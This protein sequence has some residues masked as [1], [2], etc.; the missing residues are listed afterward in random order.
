MNCYCA[1]LG[2][3]REQLAE[4]LRKSVEGGAWH[5]PSV[6]ESIAGLSAADADRRVA[7]GAHTIHE[8]LLH[9]AAWMDEVA[10]RLEGRKHKEPL[11]ADF[12]VP[13][14]W[15]QSQRVM[16]EALGKLL[17]AV[18]AVEYVEAE[19]E[20]ISG[21]AEHNTYHAGQIVMLRKCMG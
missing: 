7:A 10:E 5:G 2:T 6:S 12:P 8:L 14:D 13:V 16:R 20:L 1:R 18:R 17:S 9:V 3:M 21:A 4:I 19:L 15:E 11:M